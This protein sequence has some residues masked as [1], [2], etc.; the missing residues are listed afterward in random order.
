MIFN[1]GFSAK[2]KG[3]E[4]SSLTF[5]RLLPIGN[6]TVPP[7]ALVAIAP[8]CHPSLDVIKHPKGKTI[9]SPW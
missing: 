2:G 9:F 5:V 3:V 4:P 7:L 6:L 1:T 8:R